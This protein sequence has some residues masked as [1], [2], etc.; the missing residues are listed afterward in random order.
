VV[1]LKIR[2]G[3]LC[4]GYFSIRLKSSGG[5]WKHDNEIFLFSLDS[6]KNYNESQ[7]GHGGYIYFGSHWGPD[8]GYANS[9]RL[10]LGPMNQANGGVCN[11][12]RESLPM[13]GDS[14][15]NQS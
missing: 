4:G 14:K 12:N 9:L 13:P 3:R 6:L 2:N 11:I 10:Y 1:I 8:I 5:E 7:Q 15:V